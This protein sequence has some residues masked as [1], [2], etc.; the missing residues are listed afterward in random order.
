MNT[1]SKEDELLSA[2]ELVR[3]TGYRRARAQRDWLTN[4]GW[5]FETNGAGEPIVGR[6]YARLKLA[7]VKPTADHRVTLQ[8][9]WTPD[10]SA[11]G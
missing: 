5:I 8:P 7:G 3:I 9:A 1:A 11:L 10:F 6:W 2:D 4:K